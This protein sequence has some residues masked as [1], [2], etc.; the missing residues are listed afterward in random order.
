MAKALA[1]RAMF[2]R[3]RDVSYA[4]VYATGASSVA[5]GNTHG[6]RRF[7]TMTDGCT[8]IAIILGLGHATRRDRSAGRVNLAEL[9]AEAR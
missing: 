7:A 5:A 9:G 6:V 2:D 3:H 8:V 4:G 1:L